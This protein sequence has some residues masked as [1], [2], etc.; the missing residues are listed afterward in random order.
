MSVSTNLYSKEVGNAKLAVLEDSLR[1]CFE[2]IAIEKDDAVKNEI[3]QQ[4][5]KLFNHALSM[6]ES[7][8]FPFESLKF[9][10]KEKSADNLLRIYNWNLAYNDGTYKYFGFLQYHLKRKDRFLVYPL[11]D[12][13]AEIVNPSDQSLT[14]DNWYGSL[15]YKIILNKRRSN[16]Y[17]TLLAWHGSDD[18]ISKKIVDVVL[19]N[20]KGEPKFGAPIFKTENGIVNRIIFEY[21]RKSTMLLRY[22]ELSGMIVFDLLR[23]TNPMFEGKKAFYGPEGTYDALLFRKGK[24]LYQTNIDARNPLK[25]KK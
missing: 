16:T 21:S 10:Y 20:K 7:F 25:E 18:Y 8:D 24:W 22:D 13:S 12:K 4:I 3:N 6:N 15:Y 17:Y 11:I 9:I 19:F 2:Q 5:I 1:I 14:N 23:P